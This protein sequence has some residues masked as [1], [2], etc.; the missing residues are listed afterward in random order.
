M[1][2]I[3]TLYQPVSRAVTHLSHAGSLRFKSR[4]GQIGHSVANGSPLLRH[5]FFAVLPTGAMTRRWALQTRY[6]FRR[7]SASVM[8]DFIFTRIYCRAILN[9]IFILASLNYIRKQ[10]G[11][12]HSAA[13]CHIGLFFAEKAVWNL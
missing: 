1:K 13:T 8:K 9:E 5:F 7:N 12:F 4:A 3:F 11:R 2:F 6:R 10:Y